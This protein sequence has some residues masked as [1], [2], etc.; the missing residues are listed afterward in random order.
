MPDAITAYLEKR[1]HHHPWP[2]ARPLSTQFEMVVAIPV[3]AESERLFLTLEDLA[4]N[5]P[6]RMATTLVLCVVNNRNPTLAGPGDCADNQRTLARLVDFA[7]A[8]P[9]LHLNWIDA[10]SPGRELGDKEGV[11]LARKIGLDWG[12]H[13]LHQSGAVHAPLVSLDADTRVSPNYLAAIH[14]FFARQPGWA[15]VVDYGHPMAGDDAETRAILAYEIFLR[16]QELALHYA[17][18]PYYYPAIGSTMVCTGAAYAAAGG[19]NRR[20]AGEDFYFLQQLAKTGR[21]ERIRET[22]VLPASRPS[23]RVPFGTGRKVGAFTSDEDEAYT[24]YNPATYEV[25]RQWL[26]QAEEALDGDG[27]ALLSM[28][29]RIEPELGAFLRNQ[30]F[31]PAWDQMGTQSKSSAQRFRKFHTWFDAFRTLKLVHHLR[32]HGYLRQ[33]LFEALGTLAERAG[34]ALPVALGP[35]LR[36]DLAAQRRIIATLRAWRP[37]P[38]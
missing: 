8:H 24:T 22:T 1:A 2:L 7:T 13:C 9:Q 37:D 29:D 20:Q 21:V 12:L 5:D 31:G 36:H 32:D 11:G 19:M 26:G 34:L 4:C 6:E 25:L 28:A 23:H 18:S 33:D 16:Y 10:A 17:G 38:E 15:A 30:R 35:A 14:H 27:T 3:L